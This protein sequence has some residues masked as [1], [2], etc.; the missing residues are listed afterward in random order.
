MAAAIRTVNPAAMHRE[1]GS[2]RRLSACLVMS[3]LAL[4]SPAFASGGDGP[5]E[6]IYTPENEVMPADQTDYA[7]G[8]LGVV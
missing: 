8:R 1:Q 6:D 4:A 5:H 7:A 2:L 3:L